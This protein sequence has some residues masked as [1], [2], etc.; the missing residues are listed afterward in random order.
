MS[1]DR[2]L[3]LDGEGHAQL[4]VLASRFHAHAFPIGDEAEFKARLASI[5]QQYHDARHLCHAW[6]LGP[7]G[8]RHRANDAGEPSGTAGRPILT[9]I[10]AAGLTD[11]AVVVVR[12]FGGTLLGKAGL[13]KAY[14]ESA[15]MALADAPVKE[16]FVREPVRV[17]TGYAELEAVRNAVLNANGIV[18]STSYGEACHLDV[19]LPNGIVEDMLEIWRRQG[20]EVQRTSVQK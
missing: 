20:L 18:R 13:V 3:T 7:G 8:E 15:A 11:C 12:Y 16:C 2:Y 5:A 17:V 9:R 1:A 4:R 14:G 10:R 19:E 6:V